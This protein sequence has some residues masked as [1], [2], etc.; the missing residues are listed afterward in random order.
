MYVVFYVTN[1]ACTRNDGEQW[2]VKLSK[3]IQE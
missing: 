3:I 1:V 2:P